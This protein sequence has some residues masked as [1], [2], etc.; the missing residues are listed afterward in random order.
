[1]STQPAFAA[2]WL[3]QR[4][5]GARAVAL[6]EAAE[7]STLDTAEGLRYADALL[8]ATPIEELVQ[9]RRMSSGFVEQQ[10]LFARARR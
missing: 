7:L 8:A 5:A 10:R 3:R 1:M 2:A 6:I 9:A 4:E